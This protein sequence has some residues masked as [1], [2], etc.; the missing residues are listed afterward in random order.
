MDKK[1]GNLGTRHPGTFSSFCPSL[2]CAYSPPNSS[3]L[4]ENPSGNPFSVGGI[5]VTT[6]TTH[7]TMGTSGSGA[8]MSC[9]TNAKLFVP[10]GKLYHS[11]GG[12]NFILAP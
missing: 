8:S 9:T 5:F 12:D 4:P 1:I 7:G 11:K 10:S 6:Q 3:P 2:I